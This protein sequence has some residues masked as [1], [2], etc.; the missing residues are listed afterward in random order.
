MSFRVASKEFSLTYPQCNLEKQTLLDKLKLEKN[1]TYICIS[2]ELH[3]DGNPHLHV[4]IQFSKRKDIKNPKYFDFQG[5]HCNVQATKDSAAWNKYIKEDQDFTEWGEREE[6]YDLY[7]SARTMHHDDFFESARSKNICFQY[8]MEAWR[9]AQ[10]VDNTLTEDDTIEGSYAQQFNWFDTT[11]PNKTN[12]IIGPTGVGKTIFAKTKCKKPA[13]FCSHMDDLKSFRAGFHQSI[14]FDDMSFTHIPTTGQIHLVDL[15]E[16]RSI[17]V[18]YGIA[19]IPRGIE[20]WIT[21]N[22]MPL[23]EHDAIRRRINLIN[24]Y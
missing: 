11:I 19:R 2:K 6:D 10:Q 5:Y 20:R 7:Q 9:S 18:R 4:H 21:C 8:A 1:I 14:I 15:F 12:V 22:T 23:S 16:S 13:L 17:H 24:L 3:Q